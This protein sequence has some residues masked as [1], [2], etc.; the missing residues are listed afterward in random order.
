VIDRITT[1]LAERYRIERELGAG[2]MATVYLAQDLKHDRRVA[3]KVLKPEL[4]AVLGA[5]RFVVEIKTTAAL[6]HPHILPLFDS[7]TADGFL[8]YVMP[9]IEG[10][11]IREKLNRET[12]F[13]VDEAIRIAREVADALDYAHRHGV[14]HRDIKP[15]NIL[16]HDGRALV[17]DFGIA[18]A[19][20]AAAGGRMTETGLS[21]GT[22]HYMSPEQA[23]AEKE[24]TPRSDVYSLAT[25]LY[26]M[27]AGQPPHIG[28]AAQQVIMKILTE[29]AAPVSSMRRTVPPNVVAA[30][31]MALEKLPADR[32]VSAKAFSD[33]L[34][35][36]TFATAGSGAPRSVASSGSQPRVWIPTA[37]AAALAVA[38]LGAFIRR[39]SGPPE[40]PTRFSIARVKEGDFFE[41][42]LSISAD[43]RTIVYLETSGGVSRVYRRTLGEIA[44]AAVPGTDGA[45]EVAL[46]PDGKSVA[47]ERGDNT[48]FIVP[49]EGGSARPVVK[50]TPPAG[51]SWS[52]LHGLVLGMPSF[53]PT[54]Q[55]LTRVSERGDTALTAVT[56]PGQSMHHDPHVLDD[57]ET[58]LFMNIPIR[59]SRR[60]R[61]LAVGSV[62]SGDWKSLSVAGEVIVGVANGILVYLDGDALM[63]VRF[64]QKARR[65][66]GQ[67][68][69]V[70]G[71]PDGVSE[72]AMSSDGTL[73]MLVDAR[74]YQVASV[75]ERGE[76]Q[77]LLADTVP[78]VVPRFSPDGKHAAF[79]APMRG[80][81]ATVWLLNVADGTVSKTN[82]VAQ[83]S[84]V[85]WTRDGRHVAALSQGRK[86]TWQLADGS[87][88][89]EVIPGTE[90]GHYYDMAFGP[91]GSPMVLVTGF[92]EGGFNL[93]TRKIGGDTVDVPLV[94]TP[95]NEYA[96]RISPDGHW[97]AYASD[98][99]GRPEV[100]ARPFPGSGPRVQ[101]SI[102]G[103]GQ[104]VW[105]GDSRRIFYRSGPAFMQ[106]D[107]AATG[108]TL[109]VAARRKLF[110][111]SYFSDGNAALTATYDVSPDG[112]SF[113]VGRAVGDGGAEIVVWSGW[114]SELEAQLAKGK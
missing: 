53:S 14:I 41:Q 66:V 67:P 1:A 60:G 30:L 84:S 11:T 20:S 26:E 77:A 34:G 101:I 99:S 13:G 31:E 83:S 100:Y 50:T 71:A 63:A 92:G 109:S 17:M 37:I 38:L 36:P 97:L 108:N 7:G 72:A 86:P 85:D 114:I 2:G 59:G 27:L 76:G 32:F 105:S 39:P 64:D 80:N 102:D 33:A 28:G 45:V 65:L 54:V 56:N 12:Q 44:A 57:G 81:R 29:Q 79:S 62:S 46:S 73:A 104:P 23:T 9:Y 35:N 87:G 5:E 43:G 15:E 110:E 90:G 107:V 96:P 52:A 40:K 24:I 78:F 98:E 68:V 4:A 55:G 82:L 51:I 111:G 94:A 47:I 70:A 3:I 22:P 91:E 49:L 74:R 6:Q 75:N 19:V 106:A 58:V 10:E 103:G 69:R 18:L 21:L 48:L 25:V 8:Y 95:A 88:S 112:R 113:L 61:E 16:L 42:G 89:P 93:V